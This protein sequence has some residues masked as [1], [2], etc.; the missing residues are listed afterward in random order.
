MRVC[1]RLEDLF[2]A[3]VDICTMTTFIAFAQHKNIPIVAYN[4]HADGVL[5]YVDGTYQFT[6]IVLRPIIVVA[7]ESAVA[8]TTRII[9]NAHQKC[10]ISKSIT[11]SVLIHPSIVTSEKSEA[12][13]G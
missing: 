8:E 10:L 7:T 13:I 11:A 4:S 12:T 2:I 3:A 6:E 5:N 1:G 9:E